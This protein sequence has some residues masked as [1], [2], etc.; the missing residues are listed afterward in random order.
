MVAA[1]AAYY[2]YGDRTEIF[3]KSLQGADATL[4]RLRQ[5]IAA[6]LAKK[7]KPIFD[8]HGTMSVLLVP[9]G[10]TERAANPVGSEIY[11]ES[12]REFLENSTD[13]VIDYRTLHL[14]RNSW[15]SWAKFLS[16]SILIL[17]VWQMIV[18]GALSFIDKVGGIPIPDWLLKW[19]ALPT[20]IAVFCCLIPLPCMLRHHDVITDYRT[21]YDSP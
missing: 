14:S 9:E 8:N 3:T 18:V 21:H 20:G 6:D 11:R 17:M 10:Y 4:A 15:C 13:A 7:L 16:W 5:R 19:S 2:K 1:I 12:V